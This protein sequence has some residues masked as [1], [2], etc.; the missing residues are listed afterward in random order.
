MRLVIK[1]KNII[2]LFIFS[3]FILLVIITYFSCI[4][5]NKRDLIILKI[6]D[7]YRKIYKTFKFIIKD[8]NFH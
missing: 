3:K 2:E 1:V 4:P 8:K 6:F 5:Q 7:K